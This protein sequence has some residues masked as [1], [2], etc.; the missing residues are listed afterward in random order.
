MPEQSEVFEKCLEINEDRSA[1]YGDV[2]R[3]YGAVSNLLSAARKVDR[4]MET[5]WD[6][7]ING[8]APGIHKDALDD[9]YDAINYLAFFIR[10]ATDGNFTGER[11]ERPDANVVEI[12]DGYERRM[13]LVDLLDTA[14]DV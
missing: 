11:P 7:L 2:W 10:N 6:G 12:R 5:W 8:T 1:A 14:K 13:R 3:N 4:L 9:A